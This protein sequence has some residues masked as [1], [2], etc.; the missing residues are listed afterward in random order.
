MKLIY[1]IYKISNTINSKVYIGFTKDVERRFKEHKKSHNNIKINSKFYSATRKYGFENFKIEIIYQSLDG[2]HCLEVM[3]Q[4]FIELYDSYHMGY[5]ST[6]GGV[7]SNR[8]IDLQKYE[9]EL[10]DFNNNYIFVDNI[11]EFCKINNL[12]RQKMYDLIHGKILSHKGYRLYKNKE[13]S[14]KMKSNKV[15]NIIDK[16]DN[17]IE[18]VNINKF[19]KINNLNNSNMYK[20]IN[21]KV[22]SYRGYRL[23]ENIDKPFYVSGTKEYVLVDK[24]DNIIKFNNYNKFARDNGCNPSN[25]GDLLA[26]RKKCC[27]GFRT[28]ENINYRPFLEVVYCLYDKSNTKVEFKKITEFCEIYKIDR[29]QIYKLLKGKLNQAS[30]WTTIPKN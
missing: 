2:I 20:M 27:N 13:L 7:S 10:V 15:Y 21:G 19:C 4:Y 18:V 1:S 22:I 8:C 17:I 16:L 29:S 30:G 11:I 3:E 9:C 26:G 5:N 6:F 24:F 25:I 23:L 12:T 28:I 14:F